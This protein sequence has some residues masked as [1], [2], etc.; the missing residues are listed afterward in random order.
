MMESNQADNHLKTVDINCFIILK[1][2]KENNQ[3]IYLQNNRMKQYHQ[4]YH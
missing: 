3:K 4:D 2:L 1:I